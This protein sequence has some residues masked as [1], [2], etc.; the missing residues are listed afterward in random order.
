[1]PT[2]AIAPAGPLTALLERTS[3]ICGAA[4]IE[5]FG[6]AW[7]G[8]SGGGPDPLF[9]AGSI[10]KPVTALAALELAARGQADLDGDVNEQ[11]T[12]WHLPGPHRVSLR[13][14]LGHTAGL[15]VPFFPGYPQGTSP[16]ALQQV[17]DGAPPAATPPVRVDPAQHTRFRYSGGGYAVV[18]QLIADVTGLPFAEAARGLVLEPLG[19]ARSTFAQPLPAG[20]RPAAARRDWHVYPEAAAA[21]LWTTPGD[22]ARYVCALQAAL[23]GRPSPVRTE[24]AARL[25]SPHATLPARGEWSILPLLGMRPPDTC[26][27]GMFLHGGDRFSH[28]GGAASFFSVLT[29]SRADGTG[30]VVMTASN[31][32]PFV[33]RLLRAISDQQGWSGFRQPARNRL[34]GFPGNLRYLA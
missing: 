29:A 34:H 30:A 20:L 24:T 31:A 12:S 11:L 23:A 19:M 13:Q 4:V 28:I 21:G 17:L 3:K 7:N 25:L 32:A 9:Q 5:G 2:S 18:Q 16:P 14:L 22:L 33:F 10:S 6:V 15:G 27:L 26:G 1:M 8:G